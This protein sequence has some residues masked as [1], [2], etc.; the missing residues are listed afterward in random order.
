MSCPKVTINE[1]TVDVKISYGE[2]SFDVISSISEVFVNLVNGTTNS[3]DSYLLNRAN[4]TG[5]QAIN[6]ITGL[7]NALDEVGN[8]SP[9]FEKVSKNLDAYPYVLSYSNGRVSSIVYTTDTGTITKT[10]NYTGSQLASIVLSGD[11]PSGIE[12]TK[13]LTYTG[14]NLTEVIYS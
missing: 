12:L 7:Q 4:H 10:I 13:T 8:T 9:S 11:T 6:T 2:E 1:S 5:E 3:S 14:D